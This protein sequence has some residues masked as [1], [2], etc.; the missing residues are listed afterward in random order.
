MGIHRH[1][2]AVAMIATL[3]AAAAAAQPANVQF[4]GSVTDSC[5]VTADSAGTISI[6]GTG[7][8][9]ASTEAGGAQGQ[10]T[11]IATSATYQVELT[12]PTAFDSFPTGGDTN[13]TFAS[14]YDAAG[15]TTASGVAAGTPTGLAS[16]VTTV[17]VDVSATKSTGIFPSGAYQLTSVVTCSVP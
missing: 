10:A 8:V 6:D 13:V 3:P 9:L 5:T 14:S 11:V 17:A 12:A 15:A 16:G 2:V 4:S 7:A 1:S